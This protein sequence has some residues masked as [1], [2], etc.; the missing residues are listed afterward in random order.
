VLFTR[1]AIFLWEITQPMTLSV[2]AALLWVLSFAVVTKCW[3]SLFYD[4]SISHG[5]SSP[6]IPKIEHAQKARSDYG[7]SNGNDSNWRKLMDFHFMRNPTCFNFPWI[8]VSCETNEN[9]QRLKA[10]CG[11]SMDLPNRCDCIIK[12]QVEIQCLSLDFLNETSVPQSDR[13]FKLPVKIQ[14][15]MKWSRFVEKSH[16]V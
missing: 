8:F 13:S 16:I 7:I 14:W 5:N 15:K 6:K 12:I 9:Q 4:H 10:L 2:T 1:P 3:L 11:K